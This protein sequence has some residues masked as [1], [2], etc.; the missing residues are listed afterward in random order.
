VAG[1]CILGGLRE[2][3]RPLR[4]GRISLSLRAQNH[5]IIISV[6]M[7]QNLTGTRS[8]GTDRVLPLTILVREREKEGG[9]LDFC[10]S[11]LA[12]QTAPPFTIDARDHE[13]GAGSSCSSLVAGPTIRLGCHWRHLC[14]GKALQGGQQASLKTSASDVNSSLSLHPLAVEHRAREQLINWSCQPAGVRLEV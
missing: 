1:L 11:R 13:R 7:G 10:S 8:A 3:G 2:R 6:K 5:H 12:W 14:L 4:W 9:L